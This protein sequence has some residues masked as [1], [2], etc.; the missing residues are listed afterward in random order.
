[1][2]KRLERDSEEH[3]D[4]PTNGNQHGLKVGMKTTSTILNCMIRNVIVNGVAVAK[5]FEVIL[6][7]IALKLFMEEHN[8]AFF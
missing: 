7:F 8:N 2:D 3:T 6:S 5:S 1:M 4:H